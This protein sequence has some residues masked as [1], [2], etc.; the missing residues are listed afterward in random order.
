MQIFLLYQEVSGK[1]YTTNKTLPYSIVNRPKIPFYNFERDSQSF[2]ST[3][4]NLAKKKK[5]W[6]NGLLF[7]KTNWIKNM[8]N[9]VSKLLRIIFHFI[10]DFSF[11]NLNQILKGHSL[12]CS[13]FSITMCTYA[14]CSFIYHIRK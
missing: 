8:E 12:T 7:S 2:N 4:T 3:L 10:H 6:K 11:C 9:L 1:I 13:C 5:K 14:T